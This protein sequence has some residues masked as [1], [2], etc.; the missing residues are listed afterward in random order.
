LVLGAL[1]LAPSYAHVL[2]ALPRLA[3]WSPE[4][5]REATVFNGQFVVFAWAGAPVELGAILAV[6][7][8]A[9]RLR[10]RR[11]A[12]WPVLMAAVLYAAGLA[13]WFGI[14]APANAV[15]ASWTP[16]PVPADF[17]AVRNRWEGG[18]I[19]IAA[20]KLVAFVLLAL[21]TVRGGASRIQTAA[22]T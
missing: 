14:V 1:S 11:T 18:H 21:G 16:G 2:E 20:V 3:R 6:A 7:F 8:A 15:L 9:W 10:G 19:A 4:L 22:D 17:D 12:L 5:W 13:L